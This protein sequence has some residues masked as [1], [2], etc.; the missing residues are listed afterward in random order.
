MAQPR[1]APRRRGKTLIPDRRQTGRTTA[2]KDRPRDALS[3]GKRLSRNGR[4]YYERRRNRSD[5][6][7]GRV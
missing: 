1:K 5:L 2:R 4:L 3:P 6:P 7:P